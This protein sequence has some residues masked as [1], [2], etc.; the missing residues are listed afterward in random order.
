MSNN[1][2]G[3]VGIDG[4][5][6][7]LDTGRW[8][9]FDMSA[10]YLGSE[11]L[12]KIIPKLRDYVVIPETGEYFIVTDINNVTYIPELTPVVLRT[13]ISV[14]EI[15]SSTNDNYRTYYDRS[16]SPYTL[17]VDG[18]LR[19]NNAT[20]TTAMLYSGTFLGQVFDQTK[21]ISRRFDN[22]GN[23]I[24][25]DIPLQLVAF[26]THDNYGI[27]YVPTCNT[28]S[29]LID[30]DVCTVVFFNSDG[31]LVS[32]VTTIIEEST[33]VAQAYAEQKYI[34]QIFMKSVFI[35]DT[36]SS[37]INF[38]NN[39]PI[40]SFSPIGVV[41][42]NDGSQVEYPVDGDK[43]TL[44]GLDTFISTII[45]HS[46][47]LVLD[48]RKD[49]NESSVGPTRRP[50]ELIVSNPN[51]S[52]NVKLFVYPVWVDSVNGYSYKAFLMNLDRNIL[53]DV[54]GK[55]NLA[56]NSAAFNPVAYGITQRLTFA[57]DLATVSGIYNNYLHV[58][59][60]DII[61]RGHANDT[62][63]T[64][65]WE[66]SSQV[67]TTIPY[68]GTN[69]IAHRD[70]ITY[71]KV[72]IDNAIPTTA[73]FISRLYRSTAPLYNPMTE[74]E[75]PDPTHIEV[76]YLNESITVPISEYA[77]VFTFTQQVAFCGNIDIV[78]LKDTISGRLKLS[79]ASLT[80]R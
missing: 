15:L 25:H 9:I 18:L 63:I 6:P 26:N 7:I 39:L 22:N 10:I 43:F 21:I 47:P 48:Y 60:V 57:I 40:E 34:T 66:V 49:P 80:V 77:N 51:R 13:N 11:G 37:D 62:N 78:F 52:Y 72:Q 41:Q 54:T 50:Y 70:N 3:V 42:Y 20:A 68:Y 31:K 5:T 75:A 32:R 79:V 27:K 65:I 67:P 24:G 35:S 44:H 30:G 8:S 1:A 14:D 73:E 46:I 76:R 69:L 64:N 28:T 74:T 53:Y 29:E 55:I 19:V 16:V 38:P 36:N 45:G 58:Q 56:S 23:F 71:T 12:N 33:Y 59:T 61:L 4:S 2:I 17:T